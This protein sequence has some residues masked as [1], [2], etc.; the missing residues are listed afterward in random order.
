M[1]EYV[2]KGLAHL[3]S[4]PASCEWATGDVVAF[5]MKKNIIASRF[6]GILQHGREGLKMVNDEIPP[7]AVKVC[8][9]RYR[10]IR[11]CTFVLDTEYTE[12]PMVK[13]GALHTVARVSHST[14]CDWSLS[15]F[16]CIQEPVYFY[17]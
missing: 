4:V 17:C 16:G 2:T 15:Q 6:R 3:Y 5:L 11:P 1:N 7:F 13:V 9:K 10:L 12:E 14:L 8:T